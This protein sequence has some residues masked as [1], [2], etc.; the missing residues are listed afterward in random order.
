MADETTKHAGWMPSNPSMDQGGALAPDFDSLSVSGD[1]G[2]T[3]HAGDLPKGA[4]ISSSDSGD[5]LGA[6]IMEGDYDS[7]FP[8]SSQGNLEPLRGSGVKGA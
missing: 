8:G 3:K 5:V 1:S 7:E 2:V 4:S 6:H